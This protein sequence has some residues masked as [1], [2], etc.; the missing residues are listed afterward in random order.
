[1]KRKLL[2]TLVA[3]A[4]ELYAATATAQVGSCVLQGTSKS[5]NAATAVTAGP[6]SPVTGF[7]EYV[8]DASGLSLQRCVNDLWC[9]FDPI[10]TTD[11]FSIQI[12][13]GGEAFYWGAD[14]TLNNQAG[15]AVF[16]LTMA[17]ETA[18][19][20]GGPNGEP[21]N[22]SQFPFLRLRYVF[23]A[24]ADGVYTLSY[25][26]GQEQFEVTGATGNR[27]IFTTYDK[28]LTPNTTVIGAVGPFLTSIFQPALPAPGFV[29]DGGPT[30]V[31]DLLDVGGPCGSSVTLTGIN[32]AGAPID[33]GGGQ[34][35][36][37]TDLFTV[38][39]S[40]FDGR[41]QTPLNNGRV[42]YSRGALAGQIEAFA[43]STP[44]AL[45]KVSDGPTVPAGSS[46][47][48]PA[49]PATLDTSIVTPTGTT[50]AEGIN[51]T[52]VAVNDASA[53]PPVV[54]LLASDTVSTYVNAAGV[55]VQKFD[56]TTE[57]LRLVDFV[58]IATADFD[59][60]T[61]TL[62]V[63]ASSGD[64][65][66]NPA[67]TVRGLGAINTATSLFTTTT[68][69][70]PAVVY[71]DSAAGGTATA[72]VRVI[73]AVA[74]AAPSAPVVDVATARTV[75]L[76]WTDNSD[77][78]S[79]F[80]IYTVVNGV[81][82]AT[83][84][85]TT[86]ANVHTVTV[87]GL[88]VASS[89]TFQVEAFNGVGSAFSETVTGSTL[90]LPAAPATASFALS[91]SVQRRLDVSWDTVAG[92]TGYQ[93]YRKVGAANFALLATVPGTTFADLNG[94]GNTTYT[95]QVVA[96][97]TIAGVTDASATATTTL[98]QTTPG[99]P[100]SPSTPLA[101]VS[102]QTVTLA[103]T[104]RSSNEIGF[105]VYRRLGAGA[106]VALNA[107]EAST[108]V[109]STTAAKSYTDNAVPFGTYNYRVD[110]SNWATTSQSTLSAN[111][112]V[113]N[114]LAPTNLTA[115]T[116][117]RP[118][119]AWTDNAVGESGYRAVRTPLTVAANGSVTL[120][121]PVTQNFA[122]D[123]LTFRE[124]AGA[125]TNPGSYR[126]VVTALNGAIVGAPATVQTVIGGLPTV[127]NPTLTRGTAPNQARVTITWA[128]Q[129]VTAVGG[130]EIQRCQGAGCTS[131]TKLTGT[132][133]NTD[134]T[135][136]GRGATANLSF[137]DDT[138]VRG[139][140]Y[141]YRI[142]AIGGGK[143]SAVGGFNAVIQNVTTL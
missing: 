63:S 13:S 48:S 96:L 58:D 82:S 11:P 132:A 135:V 61:G 101:T 136:D 106:F 94:T 97:R 126:Y 51:S 59:P 86:L 129:N 12:Q 127:G 125:V 117:A 3:S 113:A 110:V 34:T 35:S 141:R 99:N 7:P 14:V 64:K 108:T 131:F 10:V 111:V 5:A 28:G 140:T 73:A 4:L 116:N 142:R 87:S 18:F 79:G 72:Q 49:T 19:L 22:G 102:G 134:G 9:F 95:Y 46:R 44:A 53:L 47:I 68:I 26:Y 66:L 60:A 120:G 45:V 21:I 33:F 17:A 114:L 57:N 122:A 25:P 88:A 71:V 70:P 133:V 40:R 121:V 15:L 85:A 55:T 39:G 74:P 90:A 138:V 130:Y 93:V 41:V 54:S 32:S 23:D 78:E 124:A 42:T 56:P 75:T 43:G 109:L 77:N 139:T 24:P 62:T 50:V 84:V 92:A 16:K 31:P 123:T 6:L 100:T 128:R 119:L 76:S 2:V 89:F 38:Q 137:Q 36:L 8:T 115:D 69:A 80:R 27:D 81:R 30:A 112:N 1:M 143:P 104:D 65:R 118:T 103:W 83:P 67:L 98:P 37:S 29:G 91:T 107:V 52:A 20:Q 105:Q